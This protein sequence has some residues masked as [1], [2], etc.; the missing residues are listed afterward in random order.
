[1]DY[2]AAA[3]Y[4]VIE[5]PASVLS[6]PGTPHRRPMSRPPSV[7]LL[8][9][10]VLPDERSA[11]LARA[12]MLLLRTRLRVQTVLSPTV[13]CAMR[14]CVGAGANTPV[15][16]LHET[17]A[18]GPSHGRP[19]VDTNLPYHGSSFGGPSPSALRSQSRAGRLL[20]FR[21]S[22]PAL[23]S[24]TS[25]HL[26]HTSCSSMP[27][28]RKVESICCSSITFQ[29]VK[30][31]ISLRSPNNT[32]P[33][34]HQAVTRLPLPRPPLAALHPPTELTAPQPVTQGRPARTHPSPPPTS[35]PPQPR[36]PP[37][38]ATSPPRPSTSVTST[39]R[40]PI[41]P[42]L[43]S[44]R[45][46]CSGTARGL[47]LQGLGG[48]T[49]CPP[50]CPPRARPLCGSLTPWGWSM[51]GASCLQSD[52][53]CFISPFPQ[54][55]RRRPLT[56]PHLPSKPPAG[57]ASPY[58]GG[59]TQPR[60]LFDRGGVPG[61]NPGIS[62]CADNATPDTFVLTHRQKGR[63]PMQAVYG[64]GTAPGGHVSAS[65]QSC[66]STRSLDI[67]DTQSPVFSCCCRVFGVS[68]DSC[69]GRQPG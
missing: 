24:R 21:T 60:S 14:M 16:V 61:A 47:H 32:P 33:P 22:C 54:R 28:S 40:R 9:S 34:L 30:D 4:G 38:V 39:G 57:R 31:T 66:R 55:A 44:S 20:L 29:R 36:R 42:H 58:Y 41:S 1:M 56:V 53:W 11:L 65:Y 46:H 23:P 51:V 17:V 10:H 15:P 35:I 8:A 27:V 13:A 67:R 6:R 45:S 25:S 69:L 18:R 48:C 59:N 37:S 52:G 2:D 5:L 64:G 49:P 68:C 50:R 3:A 12:R 7:A 63:F 62:R 19:T 43:R 26:A